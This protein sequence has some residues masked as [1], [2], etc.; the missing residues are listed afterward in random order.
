MRYDKITSKK[1]TKQS[2]KKQIVVKFTSPN[3]A[4]RKSF[5]NCP[6]SALNSRMKNQSISCISG[7][8]S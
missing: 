2:T 6:I 8:Y 7:L 3:P 5:I 1:A 4:C